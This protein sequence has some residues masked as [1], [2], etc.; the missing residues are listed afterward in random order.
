MTE[1][2]EDHPYR[3]SDRRVIAAPADRP[4]AGGRRVPRWLWSV[5]VVGVLAALL[6]ADD[7]ADALRTVS[8]LCGGV[9]VGA[10]ALQWTVHGDAPSG[11]LAPGLAMLV[12]GP[13]L[14][15]AGPVAAAAA[16]G[17][18]L[19]ALAARH[20]DVDT[21]LA[22]RT[23]AARLLGGAAAATG[24][25]ALL[26]QVPTV[27]AQVVGV[28]A[29]C[30]LLLVA[31]ELRRRYP[32]READRNTW[33]AAVVALLGLAQGAALLGTATANPLAQISG[34]VL[35][36]GA[37]GFGA[38]A[39]SGDQVR[40]RRLLRELSLAH[41][42]DGRALDATADAER[43][44]QRRWA[45]DLRSAV[46]V[47]HS[48]SRTLSEHGGQIDAQDRK[49]L[50]EA[51]SSQLERILHLVDEPFPTG[52]PVAFDL[53]AALDPVFRDLREH[54]PVDVVSVGSAA[55]MGRPTQVIAV[56]R[57]IGEFLRWWPAVGGL[58]V[59]AA[60]VGDEVHLTLEAVDARPSSSDLRVQRL[61]SDR[62]LAD[63]GGRV[64]IDHESGQFQLRF[65]AAPQVDPD[66]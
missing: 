1:T 44:Q 4:V 59:T 27:V 18:V 25:A 56:V 32:A 57:T 33:A 60:P 24:L 55:V 34:L 43:L 7:V 58:L 40:A 54:V 22:A 45:H 63:G 13:A 64:E 29:A 23:L 42:V 3:G 38:A 21:R 17:A 61:T 19:V 16:G 10:S 6:P 65:Q 11:L 50:E 5:L 31:G 51:V 37:S 9:L 48:A 12:L 2:T 15:G 49:L 28:V 47:V 30:A 62:L 52:E 66:R 20:A 53:L 8:L 36:V 35:V 14:A 46:A 41:L 39:L 26:Q